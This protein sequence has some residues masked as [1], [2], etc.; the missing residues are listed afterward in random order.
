MGRR[1]ANRHPLPLTSLLQAEPAS[2]PSSAWAL[3]MTVCATLSLSFIRARTEEHAILRVQQS[4]SLPS[5]WNMNSRDTK[6][7]KP[8]PGQHSLQ[9]VLQHHKVI[10]LWLSFTVK[11]HCEGWV[12]LQ[13]MQ[14][15]SKGEYM[16]FEVYSSWIHDV[17][18]FSNIIF[19][20]NQVQ[21]LWD[22][23]YK[24]T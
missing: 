12:T 1:V 20:L 11:V 19:P 6:R 14:S 8:A 2:L 13:L 5:W 7:Q 10:S 23:W 24:N 9:I 4:G 18:N 16:E 17:D 21:K 3:Q 22:K 15:L